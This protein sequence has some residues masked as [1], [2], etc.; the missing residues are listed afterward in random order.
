MAGGR[1]PSNG[2]RGTEPDSKNEQLCQATG[3]AVRL[4]VSPK[5]EWLALAWGSPYLAVI[6]PG[7][8]TRLRAGGGKAGSGPFGLCG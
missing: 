7:A 8:V 6:D 2:V 1:G 5:W 3:W 4:G